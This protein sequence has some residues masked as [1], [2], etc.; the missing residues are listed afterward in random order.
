MWRVTEAP[1]RMLQRYIAYSIPHTTVPQDVWVRTGNGDGWEP[2]KHHLHTSLA[3]LA[4]QR[5]SNYS[6]T[7][8]AAALHL[9]TTRHQHVRSFEAQTQFKV[10]FLLPAGAPSTRPRS[11]QYVGRWWHHDSAVAAVNWCSVSVPVQK[12]RIMCFKTLN[13]LVASSIS[14]VGYTDRQFQ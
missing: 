14:A 5:N 1:W 2:W 11:T 9:N 7:F 3:H 10:I 4:S 12:S 6:T 8:P 13:M